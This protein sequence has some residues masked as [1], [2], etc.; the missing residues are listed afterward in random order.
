M[1]GRHGRNCLDVAKKYVIY[2][3]KMNRYRGNYAYVNQREKRL[4]PYIKHISNKEGERERN[5]EYSYINV[6]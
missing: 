5:R 1:Y 3:N 4:K 6:S 2:N